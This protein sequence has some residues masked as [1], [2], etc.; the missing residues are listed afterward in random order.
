MSTLDSLLQSI[1][2]QLPEEKIDYPNIPTFEVAGKNL[3]DTFQENLLK[4][5]G[6]FYKINSIE[7]GQEIIKNNFPDA[8]VTCSATDE[9]EGSKPITSA[10]I[11]HDMEDVDIAIVRSHLGV[12]E[13]GM[14]WLTENDFKINSLG[15]LCQN[16]VVLLDPDKIT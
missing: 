10:T 1:R 7:E 11:P 5:G 13:M 8:K 2:Q 6:T 12:A 14:V 3:L 4:A 16:I 15:F 9:W